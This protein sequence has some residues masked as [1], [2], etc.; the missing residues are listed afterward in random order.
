MKRI[1]PAQSGHAPALNDL[2]C[3]YCRQPWRAGHD[4]KG[5]DQ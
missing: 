5:G 2:K 4:C 3:P 1:D